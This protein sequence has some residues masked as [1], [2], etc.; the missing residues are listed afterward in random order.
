VV[1]DP[2]E[3]KYNDDGLIPAIVQDD[4]TGEVLMMAW[5]NE[6]A[7]RRTLQTGRTTFYSR[8]RGRMWVK[9]E[10][11]GHVQRVKSVCIDCDRDTLLVRV[12]QT[13]GACH[14]GYRSCFYTRFDK[15]GNVRIVGEKVF[16][17]KDVYK[18]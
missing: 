16:D 15:D 4:E 18:N 1:S 17:P 14:N 12:E 8:S 11:S 13:G 7:V 2:I 3:L 5:M 10:E 9:G 6:E